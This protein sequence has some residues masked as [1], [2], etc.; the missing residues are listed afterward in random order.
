MCADLEVSRGLALGDVDRDGDLDA[1]ITNGDGPARLFRN[2]APKSGRWLHVRAVRAVPDGIGGNDLGALVT[3]RADGRTFRRL[4]L[5]AYSYASS[6]QPTAH[7]GLGPAAGVDEVIV[8][9]TDG[10]SERFS[11]VPIDTFVELHQGR[12]APLR[13]EERA[14]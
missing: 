3:V 5:A 8:A 14:P 13:D 12:G 4:V 6:N 1:L 9:W 11:D 7:F 10:T 2:D